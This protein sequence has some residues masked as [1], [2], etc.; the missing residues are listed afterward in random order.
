M[1]ASVPAEPAKEC[2]EKMST[3]R[4]RMPDQTVLQRRFLAKHTLQ[5]YLN[6]VHYL[7]IYTYNDIVK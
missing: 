7:K 6:H 3:L 4:I 1:G 2:G 5:V